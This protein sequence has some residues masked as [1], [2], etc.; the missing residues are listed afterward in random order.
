MTSA[1]LRGRQ[2]ARPRFV[3]SGGEGESPNEAVVLDLWG[4]CRIKKFPAVRDF[5]KGKTHICE[6][7]HPRHD[8]G[9]H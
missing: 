4:V 2:T 7:D 5:N 9:V 8:L 1:G 3:G 6:I